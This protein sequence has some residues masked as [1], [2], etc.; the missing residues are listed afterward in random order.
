M[1]EKII[2]VIEELVQA[3]YSVEQKGIDTI[4]LKLLEELMVYEE[5]M[6]KEGRVLHIDKELVGIQNAFLQKDYVNL[7]DELLYGLKASLIDSSF[8]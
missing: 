7:A 2:C 1:I 6:R 4:F 5:T 3:I 8:E